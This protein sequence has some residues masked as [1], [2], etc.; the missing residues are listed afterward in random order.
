MSSAVAADGGY[1]VDPETSESIRS[2]LESTSSIRAIANVVRVEA[3]SFD[4]LV[5]HSDV[6]A[7]WATETDPSSETG[8]PQIDRITIPLHELSA[9]PKASQRLL[10]DSAF[11]IEGWLAVSLTSLPVP[12][13]RRS[14]V[15][16]V[17]TSQRAY[18][19]IHLS[20]TTFGSGAILAMSSRGLM[21]RLRTVIR[22][23]I[24]FT[25]WVPNTV[26]MHRL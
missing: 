4:V 6:G 23:W 19:P 26:R 7:G 9:L 2:V 20:T 16:M 22:L 14:S 11:D 18:L 3:T 24:W 1:L 25:R 15:V 5:D 17:S 10:D 12:R 8:T 13:R 21:V